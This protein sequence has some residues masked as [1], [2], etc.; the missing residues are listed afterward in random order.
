MMIFHDSMHVPSFSYDFPG[1]SD[2]SSRALY[3]LLSST[4]LVAS[5]LAKSEPHRRTWMIFPQPDGVWSFLSIP[6][7]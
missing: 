4:T 2:V 1:S 5:W 3:S 6:K 7:R